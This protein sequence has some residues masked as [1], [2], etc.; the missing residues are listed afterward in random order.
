MIGLF[1]FQTVIQ[2]TLGLVVPKQIYPLKPISDSPETNLFI[3][4]GV[5][6]YEDKNSSAFLKPNDGNGAFSL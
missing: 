5:A 4:H 3:Q 1:I 6:L 2:I